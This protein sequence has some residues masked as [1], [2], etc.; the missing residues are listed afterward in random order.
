MQGVFDGAIGLSPSDCKGIADERSAH[1][2][3]S[4]GS[5]QLRNDL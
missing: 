4:I 5:I 3:L 2:G 1:A